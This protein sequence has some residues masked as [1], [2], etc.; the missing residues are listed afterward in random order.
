[1]NRFALTLVVLAL[2]ATSAAQ[3]S[4]VSAEAMEERIR[5]LRLHA[6]YAEAAEVARELIALRKAD[7]EAKSFEI[8]D[9]D[10]LVETLQYAAGLPKEAQRELALAD[11]LAQVNV[12]CREE[13]R[14]AEAEAA[15]RQQ[16]EIRRRLLGN[17][18]RD[19][20]A[21]LHELA[22]NLKAQG[23]YAAAEP[24]HREA[25]AMLRNLHGDEHPDVAT[26]L[27]SLASLLYEQGD[28][29]A[30][31]PL[32]RE[33]LAMRRRLLG[34][35]HPDI[36]SC[37]N[38]LASLLRVQGDYTGAE[39]LFREALAMRRKLLGDEHSDVAW[40][41]SNLA[42]LLEDRGDYANAEPLYRESLEMF[43]NLHGSEHLY[44]AQ[45][46][47][48]LA[49]LLRDRG[50]YADA[51]LLY[52]E[53]LATLRTLLGDEHPHIAASLNNLAA[54]LSAQGDNAGAEPLYRESLAILR[55]TFGDEHPYVATSLNN[56]ASVLKSQGDYAGAEE[57]CRESLAMQRRLVG[58]EHPDVAWGLN[59]LARLLYVQGDYSCAEPLF[60]EALAM[61]RRLLGDEHPRVAASLGNLAALLYVQGDY[62]AAE[63]L[64]REALAMRRKLLGDEHPDVATDLNNLASLLRGRGDYAAAEPLLREALAMRRKLLGGE[65]PDVATSLSNLA[66]VLMAQGDYAGAELLH[67]EALAMWRTLLGSEHPD[68]AGSQ[69]NLAG[70]LKARGNY[71]DAELLYR[72]SLAMRRR[73]LGDKH[74][75]VA[76]SLYSLADLLET[77]GDYADAELLLTEAGRAHDAARLR[78]GAGLRRASFQ[79]SPYPR[80][81]SVKLALGRTDEAWPAAE[82][83]HARSL[84]DLLMV[85]E[86]RELSPSESAREDSLKRVLG[87]LERELVAYREAVTNDTTGEAVGHV[88]ETRNSLFAAES[89][90]SAFQSDLSAKYPVTEGE[91]FPLERVQ[92]ALSR[93]TAIIGWMDVPIGR[94]G[95]DTQHDDSWCYAIRSSGSVTWARVGSSPTEGEERSPSDRIRSLRVRLAS[96]SSPDAAVIRESRELWSERI[97]PLLGA[98]EGVE[99]LIVVPSGSML[100][101]PI[102]ALVDNEGISM[103]EMYA[104]S[105]APSA[106]LHTWLAERADRDAGSGTL[107]VGDPP[108]NPAHLAA[109]LREDDVLLASAE[110]MPGAEILRSAL[111]GNAD[112]L[113]ALPRLHGT[114][115]EVVAM[116]AVS[117]PSSLLLG[118][119]A[120]EQELVRLA[121]TGE[122]AEFGTI[123]MATHALIDD[124]QPER[125]ALVLSQVDLPDPL[126]SAMAGTR[127]HDGLVTAKEI[128]R[129]WDLNADLVTLSACETALG[130]EVMGEGYVGFAY[131]FL[132]AGARSLL[133]SLW[134]VEDRAT[135]LLMRRFYENRLGKY[136]DERGGSTGGPMSKSEAL[137]EAKR[138]LRGYTDEY[139]NH[140]YEHPYF[141][142]AFILIGDPS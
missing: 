24:L 23:D 42:G 65:H 78:A 20:A 55:G 58:D 72:E 100:G 61:E 49:G 80:L 16:L 2:A 124:E 110:P 135:S 11:S 8:A 96:P 114:R 103:G 57:L 132:Q 125:S 4:E 82:K 116:A 56:L 139:G 115:D 54:L 122:L 108:Y 98:F 9:A 27:N 134:R 111:A 62:A 25:L 88:E 38:N 1:M 104:V 133:V 84:A 131:A 22:M 17:T 32:F 34:D 76:E 40:S 81:A 109:M 3:D 68:V 92:L 141:W 142:S 85:A 29:S 102:E 112:A 70:L 18:H 66:V 5:E 105:Y 73:F 77:Q 44:V 63:P 28:Y 13:T 83:A 47:N 136:M 48:N 123:H 79:G 127:I 87:T 86:G 90:W 10:R 113:R 107:L 31:E 30:A 12:T 101:V 137:R 35:E 140:P 7:P 99:E 60:R 121:E 69:H 15:V 39:P 128:L 138:W 117:E 33:A 53:S 75:H 43:R 19:I 94:Y 120:T 93:G 37:L 126:E 51:E 41:L 91:A 89:E 50:N 21:S 95:H 71:A 6:S 14:Y 67:L 130:K 97:A 118:P 74:P 46:L 106:T 36:A 26:G 59:S 119:A 45:S 64:F 52:R 129:E